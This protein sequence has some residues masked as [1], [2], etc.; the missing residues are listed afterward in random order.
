MQIELLLFDAAH[1]E[2]VY[3][4]YHLLSGVD[5]P[6]KSQDYIHEF[7]SQQR[8][9]EF[10]GFA[11]ASIE[12][13]QWRSRHYFLFSRSFKSKNLLK[14]GIRAIFARLQSVVGYKHINGEV[15]KGCQW[16]SVTHDFVS[17]ILQNKDYINKFN[18]TYC[19]DEMFIQTLCY[20]SPFRSQV[21]DMEDEFRGCKRYIKW[22]NGTN[23]QTMDNEDV[24]SLLDSDRWFARKFTE[25]GLEHLKI[26]KSMLQ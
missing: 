23:I 22:K 21:Y 13:I 4:Y 25:K 3:E 6:I 24:H 17:Y 26:L 14:R 20:N 11:D 2:E 8:G 16:C 19:P 12:E 9:K 1:K 10:I 5:F 7:C 15:K 18:H